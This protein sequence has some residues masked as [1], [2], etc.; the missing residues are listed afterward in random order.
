MRSRSSMQARISAASFSTTGSCRQSVVAHL[1]LSRAAGAMSI[2]ESSSPQTG[3][4]H[5]GS[6][7]ECARTDAEHAF[8]FSCRARR[9]QC[10]KHR[11]TGYV[12]LIRATEWGYQSAPSSSEASA[13]RFWRWSAW[14][15][16]VTGTLAPRLQN[17]AQT[18]KRIIPVAMGYPADTSRIRFGR[19]QQDCSQRT[20]PSKRSAA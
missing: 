1:R 15:S 6:G 11:R 19:T 14:K 8:G 12:A 17:D 4:G 7:C 2:S 20:H 9:T 10:V 13:G 3:S 5:N 16:G 18:A